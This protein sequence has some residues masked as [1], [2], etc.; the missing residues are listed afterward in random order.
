M[1][2]PENPLS[3]SPPPPPSPEEEWNSLAGSEYL[4][5]LTA[6]TFDSFLQNK[7]VLVMFYAPCKF[8]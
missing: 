2:D 7:V 8:V 4:Q 3:G 6:A 1:S 5:H